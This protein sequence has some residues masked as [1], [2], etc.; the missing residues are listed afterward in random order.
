VGNASLSRSRLE[1][2]VTHIL[3]VKKVNLC[4]P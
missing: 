2:A 4:R 1:N 3:S